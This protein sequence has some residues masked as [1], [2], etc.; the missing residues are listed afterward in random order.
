MELKLDL[1][2]VRA[3]LPLAIKDY[4]EEVTNRATYRALNR[5]CAPLLTAVRRHVAQQAG[6][7]YGRALKV[8]RGYTASSGNLKYVIRASD[9]PIPLIEFAKGAKPGTKNVR[10]APWG[11]SRTFKDTFVV[12]FGGKVQVV[13]RIGSHD[14]GPGK[15]PLRARVVWGPILPKEMLR[16]NEPSFRELELAV[17]RRVIPRLLHELAFAAGEAKA[18]SGT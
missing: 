1:S 9:K 4:G 3:K 12:T 15:G 16:P 8:I 11:K 2:Q 17:P 7:P 5:A 6:V 13:K 10:A 14:A 18:R